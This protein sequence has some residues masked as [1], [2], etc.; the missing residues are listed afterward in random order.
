MTTTELE[1]RLV[2]LE[3]R[4]AQ[5]EIERKAPVASSQARLDKIFGV[6]ANDPA[7]EEAV[8]AGREW[9]KTEVVFEDEQEVAA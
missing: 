5:M 2:R 4:V 8:R 1:D 6:F 7:F 9:R 3:E